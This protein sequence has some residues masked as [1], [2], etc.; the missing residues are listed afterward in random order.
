[1]LHEQEDILWLAEYIQRPAGTSHFL[2]HSHNY[3]HIQQDAVPQEFYYQQEYFGGL[4]LT[5]S[6]RG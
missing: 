5:A 6:D 3:L 1:M 2:L 4:I